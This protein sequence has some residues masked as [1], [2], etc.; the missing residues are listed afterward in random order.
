[1]ALNAVA[2]M[3]TEC[4]VVDLAQQR[5]ALLTCI[6]PAPLLNTSP[7]PRPALNLE[8]GK[9]AVKQVLEFAGV[10]AQ[11]QVGQRLVIDPGIVQPVTGDRCR[12]GALL[13]HGR[14]V[15]IVGGITQLGG[16]HL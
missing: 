1:M 10:Q 7:A 3:G 4:L 15:L 2:Y 9:V 14:Q 6:E 11:R 8:P 13:R 16:I 5:P 12:V